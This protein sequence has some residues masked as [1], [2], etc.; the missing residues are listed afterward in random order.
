MVTLQSGYRTISRSL[1]QHSSQT[2]VL[3]RGKLQPAAPVDAKRI[4]KLMKTL[5]SDRYAERKR[6]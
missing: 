2:V 4:E 1:L 6:Q 5:D 3:L